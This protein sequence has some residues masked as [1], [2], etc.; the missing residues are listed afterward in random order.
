[1]ISIGAGI[2]PNNIG[3]LAGWIASSQH[4]KPGNRMPSFDAFTGEE[5]RALAAYLESLK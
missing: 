2:L 5:L 3:T 4:L 1:R